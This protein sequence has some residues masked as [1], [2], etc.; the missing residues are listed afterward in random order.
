MIEEIH[1]TGAVVVLLGVRGG[2]LSDG[3]KE[4]YEDLAEE[5]QTAFVSNVLSGVF[6]RSNLMADPIHPNNDGYKKISERVIPVLES[7]I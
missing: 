3:Y 4:M 2:L 1:S 5:H 7:V 6:G